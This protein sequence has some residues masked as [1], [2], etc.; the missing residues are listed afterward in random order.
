AVDKLVHSNECGL[1]L[2]AI[3]W[4]ETHHNS[5]A[6]ERRQMIRDLHLEP[7]SMVV[8]AGCGP[9]L[10]TPLLAQAIGAHGRIIGVDISSEALI[11]AQQRSYGKWYRQQ[12]QYKWATMEH[13]PIERGS[14]DIIF[15]ANVSQYLPNPIDTFAAMGHYPNDG[16]RLSIKDV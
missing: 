12:V 13:L 10:W 2:N 5:K 3:E 1:P 9:G 6:K 14:A 4:L 15:S 8:D 7:G 11:T 16:G